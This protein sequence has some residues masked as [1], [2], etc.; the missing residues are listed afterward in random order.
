MAR[1]EA[2]HF[3]AAQVLRGHPI[4]LRE[5]M[6]RRRDEHQILAEQRFDRK[7]VAVHRQRPEDHVELAAGEVERLNRDCASIRKRV[8]AA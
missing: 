2:Q 8:N 7:R 3:G 6:E 5:R 1:I 4:A